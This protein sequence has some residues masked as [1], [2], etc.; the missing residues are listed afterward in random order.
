MQNLL[1]FFIYV[2]GPR[3]DHR[4]NIITVY[5]GVL[6]DNV[7]LEVNVIAYPG[8]TDIMWYHRGDKTDKWQQ[9][10]N[11]PIF[12]SGL[13]SSIII[14]LGSLADFGDYLVNMSN[15]F[16]IYDLIF[17][18]IQASPPKLVDIFYIS[19]FV[20]NQIEFHFKPGFNGGRVQSFAIEYK[21]TSR[22]DPAWRNSSVTDLKET[23]TYNGTY[24]VNV[25]QPPLGSYEYR[26]Y[27]WNEIGRSP[28]SAVIPIFIPEEVMR[29]GI[30]NV[31]FRYLIN[32]AAMLLLD[33]GRSVG[34]AIRLIAQGLHFQTG[35]VA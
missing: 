10:L 11:E 28:Y 18:V 33:Y 2:G 20:S 7:T 1:L 16:G 30:C 15:S 6:K 8:P 31:T 23:Q 26:M 3:L 4:K 32:S 13:F 5:Y 9:V 19:R 25:T 22:P 29:L 35:S 21:S 14:H 24:D 17:H 27:S 34:R 12:S